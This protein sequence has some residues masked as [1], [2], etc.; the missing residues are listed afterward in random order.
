MEYFNTKCGP[1]ESR[2]VTRM[3]IA[4]LR[5]PMD[6][7]RSLCYVCHEVQIL[8]RGM[9]A[10]WTN[11]QKIAD[12]RAFGNSHTVRLIVWVTVLHTVQQ[13]IIDR[14]MDAQSEH[15]EARSR[16][17]IWVNRLEVF[18]CLNKGFRRSMIAI[19]FSKKKPAKGRS[20]TKTEAPQVH[21]VHLFLKPC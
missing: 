20:I 19:E 10:V 16:L 14:L 13:R 21:R 8:R 2:R 11:Y 5:M 15:D 1:C 17:Y 4:N 6:L 3:M 9:T 7:H 18:I 12:L